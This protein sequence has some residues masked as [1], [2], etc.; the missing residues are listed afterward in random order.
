MKKIYCTCGK[1]LIVSS[2]NDNSI[3]VSPCSC[4]S[5]KNELHCPYGHKIK[6]DFLECTDKNKC[7]KNL[8]IN[9]CQGL[10]NL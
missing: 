1:E 2:E 10:W 5:A 3:I 9:C 4:Q 8:W 6:D 7:D